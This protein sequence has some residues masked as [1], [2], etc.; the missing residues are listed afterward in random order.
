MYYSSLIL[1]F[2]NY[3]ETRS[4][5]HFPCLLFILGLHK[6]GTGTE[7]SFGVC[8]VLRGLG[9]LGVLFLGILSK[10]N[11]YFFFE[12]FPIFVRSRSQ[13]RNSRFFPLFWSHFFGIKNS[14]PRFFSNFPVPNATLIYSV[15][16]KI[17]VLL[18]GH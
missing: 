13:T 3:S 12:F 1:G 6:T 15:T 7:N 9:G 14:R 2:E 8:G 11:F 18:F 16:I 17:R 10:K 4:A 5:S